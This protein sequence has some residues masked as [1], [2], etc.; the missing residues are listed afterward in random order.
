MS[1]DIPKI[2]PLIQ[3]TC[4]GENCLGYRS[5]EL[6]FSICDALGHLRIPVVKSYMDRNRVV[7]IT[8]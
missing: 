6:D 1:E 8:Q 5:I 7:V 3:K 2:C 4:I